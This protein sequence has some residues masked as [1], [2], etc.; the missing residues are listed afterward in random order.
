MK[1]T[2]VHKTVLLTAVISSAL[3]WA[4]VYGLG[5]APLP[6]KIKLENARVKVTEVSGTPGVPREPY[7]R[8][9]DQVI[10]FLDDC[11]YQVKDSK[12]EEK[13][14]R[15]RK[16]GDVIWHNKGE[17]APELV[18]LGTKPYRTVVIELK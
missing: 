15:E 2:A 1:N 11:K 10:V 4:G 5:W 3:T 13:T 7:V 6:S 9:S 18:N 8:P 17:G 16:S 12:T 14:V